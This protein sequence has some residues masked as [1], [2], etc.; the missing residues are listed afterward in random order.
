MKSTAIFIWGFGR[1]NREK[2]NLKRCLA[3]NFHKMR[4][5]AKKKY[6]KREESNSM[7]ESTEGDRERER[8]RVQIIPQADINNW[9]YVAC[10]SY[11]CESELSS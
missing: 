3:L 7:K 4:K 2:K 8:D 9:V 1:K 11:I 10:C 6:A 5:E